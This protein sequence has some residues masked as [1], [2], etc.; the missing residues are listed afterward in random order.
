MNRSTKLRNAAR[1]ART[2]AVAVIASAV[3]LSAAQAQ[4]TMPTV[5]KDPEPFKAMETPGAPTTLVT[6]P[7]SAESLI[8]PATGVASPPPGFT[9]SKMVMTQE[10]WN[11]YVK[12]VRNDVAIGF[13]LF[14]V[15]VDGRASYVEQ[16]KNYA[17]QISPVSRS[18]AM[19]ECQDTM[20]KR[21]C[22]VFAEGRDIKYAYQVVPK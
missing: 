17:C 6:P 14:L 16:C 19:D 3:F 2:A 4:Q 18:K 9:G 5:P 1:I 7:S 22:V 13:G 21:R 11:E 12:Y 10:V 15:T 20:N 8:T